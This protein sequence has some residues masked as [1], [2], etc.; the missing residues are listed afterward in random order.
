MRIEELPA[1]AQSFIAKECDL[2]N[3]ARENDYKR[4]RGFEHL[5]L[6]GFL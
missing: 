3:S 4:L 1:C 2:D 6:D 5:F